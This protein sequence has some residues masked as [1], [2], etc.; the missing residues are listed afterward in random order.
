MTRT[1]EE[2]AS[3]IDRPG[4]DSD[5]TLDIRAIAP[6]ITREDA[7]RVQLEVKRRRV[8]AG[9]RLVGRQASFTSAG[10]RKMFPDSPRPMVGSLLGSLVRND[11]GEVPLDADES[12]LECE[13][14][15]ILKKDLR[16][17]DLTDMDVLAAIDCF[18]PAI[19]IA[20]LRPGVRE[21]AYSYEHLIAMQKADGGYVVFGPRQTPARGVDIVL[22]ACIATVDGEARSSGTGFE[23][24]GSPLRVVAAMAR[25]LSAVGETL[26]AGEVI[27]TGALPPPPILTRDNRCARADFSTL[28][29]VSVRFSSSGG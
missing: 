28:G 26:R 29:S 9:D 17:P 23:A 7:L 20:P 6:D 3:H 11:G 25:T 5:P 14:A 4:V 13:I 16:G 2:L 8:L 21:G 15:L 18:L 1:I 22:E 27:M 19:E 12:F 24:M 10:V